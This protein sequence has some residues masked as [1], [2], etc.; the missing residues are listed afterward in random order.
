MRPRKPAPLAKKKQLLFFALSLLFVYGVLEGVS[1][2]LLRAGFG[3]LL[4]AG[5]P[6]HNPTDPLSSQAVAS[7]VPPHLAVLSLHPYL[8]YVY[9]RERAAGFSPHGFTSETIYPQSDDQFVVGIFGG[10]VADQLFVRRHVLA[11]ALKQIP[12]LTR[13]QVVFANLAIG[14]FKQPQ[15]LMALTYMLSLGGHFDLVI[16]VDGFNEV[17]LPLSENIPNHVFPFFPRQWHLLTMPTVSLLQAEVI[18]KIA[19]WQGLSTQVITLCSSFPLRYSYTAS[20]VGGLVQQVIETRLSQWRFALQQQ[21]SA[22]STLHFSSRGPD[23]PARSPEQTFR[24]LAAV[25]A[26]SSLQMARL[27]AA[28]HIRYVHFLQP[29]QYLPHTKSMSA[30]ERQVAYR[31]DQPYRAGVV[32]GYPYLLEQGKGLASQ[33]VQFFDLTQIFVSHPEAVYGDS[34]CHFNDHGLDILNMFIGQTVAN[35]FQYGEPAP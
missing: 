21:R 5:V 32:S 35:V 1:L 7:T 19:I 29:N 6:P 20:L 16:N 17:T 22:P 9:D 4:S 15:Q 14:G 23:Y 34:C 24:D 10:S 11:S 8:G 13:K 2:L 12:A 33:G 25:W 28:N 18:G 31:E 26:H 3:A 27:C 30:A